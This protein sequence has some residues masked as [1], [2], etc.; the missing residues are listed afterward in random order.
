MGVTIFKVAN[1]ENVVSVAKIDESDEEGIELE[2]GDET[3]PSDDAVVG[4]SELDKPSDPEP[5]A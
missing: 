2:G 4:E 3:A 5:D 1:N